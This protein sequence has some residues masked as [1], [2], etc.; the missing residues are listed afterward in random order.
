M[1][2]GLHNFL[3]KSTPK[4]RFRQ[5]EFDDRRGAKL[6]I[7]SI[8]LQSLNYGEFVSSGNQSFPGPHKGGHHL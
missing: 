3:S 1:R 2:I 5:K 8:V 7:V 4:T 6:Y